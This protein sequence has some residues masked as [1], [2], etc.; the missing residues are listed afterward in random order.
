MGGGI[1]REEMM[2]L[3]SII[4]AWPICGFPSPW[5]LWEVSICAL[6]K[7]HYIKAEYMI[8]IS[9]FPLALPQ[10]TKFSLKKEFVLSATMHLVL[11]KKVPTKKL[12]LQTEPFVMVIN[13]L[14]FSELE[15][16]LIAGQGPNYLEPYL[17]LFI[18]IRVPSSLPDLTLSWPWGE[19]HGI[20]ECNTSFL[21]KYI[22]L[23]DL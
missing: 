4:F 5:K 22:N 15:D 10:V 12:N 21:W 17:A 1:I 14:N 11:S 6:S 8:E 9:I 18:A 16:Y 19:S 23:A 3:S 13:F 2:N 20:Y 7:L